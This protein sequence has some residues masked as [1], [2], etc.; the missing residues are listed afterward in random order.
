MKIHVTILS[1][2]VSPHRVI[3]WGSAG[4][5]ENLGDGLITNFGDNFCDDFAT[6][7][8]TQ[9]GDFFVDLPEMV[10]IEVI[11]LALY[12]SV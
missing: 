4:I 5:S 9:Y 1:L 3:F 2:F 6:I 8:F 12:Q 10:R 11:K 7:C